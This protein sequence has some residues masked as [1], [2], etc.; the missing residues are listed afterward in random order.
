MFA[1]LRARRAVF[2]YLGPDRIIAAV[3]SRAEREP[4]LEA[5]A[6]SYAPP[7]AGSCFAPGVIEV[8]WVLG[9]ERRVHVAALAA[10]L[11]RM[12]AC[13]ELAAQ[14]PAA[15]DEAVASRPGQRRGSVSGSDGVGVW[16]DE[17][18]VAQAGGVFRRA[19]LRLIA[20]DCEPC[21]IASLSE[22]L[23][24]SDAE[25]ARRQHLS[26]VAV[27][28]DCESAAEALGDDLAVPVGL[29]VSWFGAGRAR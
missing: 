12:E 2:W 16:A 6:A 25:G 26:A 15:G 29:A 9:C 4:V 8:A 13:D 5:C 17:S 3:I 22:A 21:A 14:A 1:S 20:L 19:G 18:A 11:C 23:G 10:S 24:T 7:V 27:L 28:P